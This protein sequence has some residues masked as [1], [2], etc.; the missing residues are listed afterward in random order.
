MASF[1]LVA[2]RN[3][4]YP[5]KRAHDRDILGRVMRHA[6]IAVGETAAAA[7]DIDIGTVVTSIIPDLLQAA[8]RREVPYR[9]R[10]YLPAIQRKA[11]AD[12]NHVLL[13][14]SNIDKPVRE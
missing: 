11:G 13:G 6:K 8:K 9:I 3:H 5:G 7:Y 12:T 10:E 2:R 4:G 1:E 14:D